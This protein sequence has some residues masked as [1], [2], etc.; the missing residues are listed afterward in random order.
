VLG[1][2]LPSITLA[3]IDIIPVEIVVLIEIIV[4]IDV[5]VAVVPVAIAPTTAPSAP[6]GSAQ[7]N[8]GTPRQSRSRHVARISIWIIRIVDRSSSVNDLWII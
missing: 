1:V 4:V 7:R 2:V 5:N 6:G 8:S 3:A